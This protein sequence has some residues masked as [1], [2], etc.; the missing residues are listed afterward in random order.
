MTTQFE[1]SFRQWIPSVSKVGVNG[2]GEESKYVPATELTAYWCEEQLLHDIIDAINPVMSV[3][4]Q[5]ITEQYLGVFST[6]VYLGRPEAIRHFLALGMSD[7]V[8]LFALM[9]CPMNGTTS[10]TNS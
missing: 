3:P 2:F 4:Y 10:L 6:L 7:D 1:I 9:N 5:T 8:C